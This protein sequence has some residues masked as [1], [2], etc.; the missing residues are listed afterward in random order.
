VRRCLQDRQ[1][2][3]GD[4]RLIG[5]RVAIEIDRIF[6]V[7]HIV[8]IELMVER[9]SI[10]AAKIKFEAIHAHHLNLQRFFSTRPIAEWMQNFVD[11]I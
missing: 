8:A 6:G 7:V 2:P 1:H 10:R 9:A 4:T 3:A 5:G 11:H